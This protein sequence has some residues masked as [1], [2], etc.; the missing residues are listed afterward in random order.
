MVFIDATLKFG[1][2]TSGKPW[3]NLMW[4]THIRILGLMWDDG[5]IAVEWTAGGVAYFL[6]EAV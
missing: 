3:P 1:A 5:V 2:S 4:Q 6:I